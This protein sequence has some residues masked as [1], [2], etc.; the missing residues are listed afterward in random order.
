MNSCQ[1]LE[2]FISMQLFPNVR[3]NLTTSR[4]VRS[5]A[6]NEEWDKKRQNV[7]LFQ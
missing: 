6:E 4:M 3:S 5:Q 7:L 2:C 1:S